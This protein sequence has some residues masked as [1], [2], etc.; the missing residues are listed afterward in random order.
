MELDT[1]LKQQAGKLTQVFNLA[2]YRKNLPAPPDDWW[3]HLDTYWDEKEKESH[4]W[5]RFDWL[6][7][8]LRLL[9]WTGNL[10]LLG[11]LAA[12]FFSGGSGLIEAAAI[13]FPGLLS[14]LQA[15]SELTEAGQKSFDKLLAKLRI[16]QHFHEE[17]KLVSTLSITLLLLGIWVK[18]PSIAQIYNR[19]GLENQDNGQIAG[20]EQNY[21]KAIELDGDNLDAHYNLATLY[22][23][24]QDF[25]NAQKQYLIAAKGGL[26]DAYNNLARLYIQKKKYAEAVTL[27]NQGLKLM[28]EKEGQAN[29]TDEDRQS[30]LVVKYNLFKNLGWARVEQGQDENAQPYLRAAIGIASNPEVAKYIRNPGASYCLLAQVLQRQED[31]SAPPPKPSKAQK[32]WQQCRDLVE[33]RL[34]AGEVINP[35]ED[36]WLEEAKQKLQ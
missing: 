3:W 5:N 8:I 28:R 34:A 15:Q 24:L 1:R 22:E 16:P 2:E 19:K 4:P 13:A 14:L 25:N 27:L 6:W 18:L 12:R 30:L 7:R 35:E 9:A 23:D 36:T 17:A 10:A 26:P 11:T 31:K 33:K 29:L 21:L 20:A 32:Y